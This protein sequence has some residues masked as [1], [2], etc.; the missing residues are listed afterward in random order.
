MS[1]LHAYFIAGGRALE[2]IVAYDKARTEALDALTQVFEELHA[3]SSEGREGTMRFYLENDA[4]LVGLKHD[5]KGGWSADRK[6]PEGKALAKRLSAI[7]IPSSTFLKVGVSPVLGEGMRLFTSKPEKIGETWVLACPY[8]EG[9][10]LPQPWDSTPILTSAYW[11][12]KEAEA[13]K[14][15]EVPA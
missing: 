1:V 6:T 2:A 10:T 9:K 12:M 4:P 13:A 14:K 7:K 3:H 8:L 11:A 15:A 5:R